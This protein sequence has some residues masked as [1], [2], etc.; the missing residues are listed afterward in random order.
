MESLTSMFEVQAGLSTIFQ[1]GLD[2]VIL[3]LLV[4]LLAGRKQRVSGNSEAVIQSFEEIIE[5]TTAISREFGINLEQRRESIQQITATLD[6]RL[7]DAQGMC[8]RMELMSRACAENLKALT[9]AAPAESKRDQGKCDQRKVLYLAGKGLGAS[10]I[11]KSLKKPLGEV[12]LIL[13]LQR[14]AT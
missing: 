11:A 13:N 3:G 8:E 2:V 4:A 6:R 1:I 7:Q 10:E 14:I 5:Q 12:E 9:E